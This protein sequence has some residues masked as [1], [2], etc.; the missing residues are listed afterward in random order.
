MKSST[1]SS[2]IRKKGFSL[3]ELIFAII[4][5]AIIASVAVPKLMGINEKAKASTINGD[6][7]TIISSVQSYYMVHKKIDKISDSIS[8]NPSI[9]N[10][11]DKEVSF[12]E[13]TKECIK[14]TVEATSINL[15]IDE[16]AGSVCKELFASGIRNDIFNLE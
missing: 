9:W 13:N 2:V 6:I 14:I 8:L 4:I 7:S 15:T 12:K 11:S 16:S 3:I 10:I 5:I 1:K